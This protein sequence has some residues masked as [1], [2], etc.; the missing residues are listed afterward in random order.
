MYS[1]KRVV[2]SA[3]L[4]IA[5]VFALAAPAQAETITFVRASANSS[6]NV[7]DQIT[8]DLSFTTTAG[9]TTAHFRFLNDVGETASL[10]QIY[11]NDSLDSELDW[12]SV[13][14]SDSDT[15]GSTDV[16]YTSPA[17]PP[18]PQGGINWG[19]TSN[20][21]YSAKT[22]TP[23]ESVDASDEWVQFDF[24]L[25]SGVTEQDVIDAFND[26][27]GANDSLIAIHAQTLPPN[28]DESDWFYSG[29]TPIQT[30]VPE[31]ASIALFALGLGGLFF[32]RRRRRLVDS[33]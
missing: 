16:V 10:T 25:D 4:G 26:Q 2:L 27:T 9:V 28:G 29:G 5:G 8:V 21:G 19:G 33:A 18:Q 32:E 11:F 12:T 20:V 24:T 15:G 23:A 1:I 14:I 6:V 13:S 31:P 7:A 22:Q 30:I 17:S 3:V